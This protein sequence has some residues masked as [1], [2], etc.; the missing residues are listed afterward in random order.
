M[1]SL[2]LPVALA[3]A[4]TADQPQPPAD[5]PL[6][7]AAEDAEAQIDRLLSDPAMPER[8]S[9]MTAVMAE[10]MEA[11]PVGSLKAAVEGRD[12]TPQEQQERLGDTIDIDGEQMGEELAATF[13]DNRERMRDSMNVLVRN[14]PTLIAAMEQLTRELEE[15]V[16][17]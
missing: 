3:L 9:R 11:L 10:M 6:V 1:L 5:E 13:T 14:M 15:T 4:S 7:A 16:A 12:P 8:L 17:R 2:S